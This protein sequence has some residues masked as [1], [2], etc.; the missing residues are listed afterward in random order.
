MQLF[1]AT[2]TCMG[3]HYM[4]D[5]CCTRCVV[6]CKIYT[7]IFKKS[8]FLTNKSIFLLRVATMKPARWMEYSIP[9]VGKVHILCIHKIHLITTSNNFFFN[10]SFMFTIW[11]SY[12]KI[13]SAMIIRLGRIVFHGQKRN[14]LYL[15][16]QLWQS[17]QNVE[18]LIDDL[19][20]QYV[21][22]ACALITE[23]MILLSK[24]AGNI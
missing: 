4:L 3:V 15:G 10:N 5:N 2:T 21:K 8:I 6:R 11:H 7:Y 16:K 1:K 18:N 13:T 9:M 12:T 22:F 19:G 23:Q 24:I 14:Y 17:W 20:W